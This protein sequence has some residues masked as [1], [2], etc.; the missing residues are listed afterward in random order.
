MPKIEE[1][2]P[3]AAPLAKA[4]PRRTLWGVVRSIF[5]PWINV[6]APRSPFEDDPDRD[7]KERPLPSV[8]RTEWYQSDVHAAIS[9]A[10]AGDLSMAGQ[11]WRSTRR[12]GI[13]GGLLSTRAGGLIR[14]PK[15]F[16][17]PP[18]VLAE[19]QPDPESGRP[20][21]FDRV[22]PSKELELLI[23]DGIGLGVG[24]GE[25]LRIPGRV[26]P[27]FVRLDPEFL[28]YRWSED[29][30]YYASAAG[31]LPITPGDGRWVLHMPG[32]YQQP[33]NNGLWHAIAR[34]FVA[35]EHAFM[36]RENYSGKLA[37]PA[38][39]AVSPQGAT[40]GERQ[41]FFKRVMAWGLNTVFG[42]PPGWDV[43][44]LEINGQGF[45]VFED[46]IEASNKEYA[47]A[48]AGQTVTVDGGAGFSN[49]TIHETIR[50]DLIQGDGS[51]AAETLNLQAF[52]YVMDVCFG[53]GF[54]CAVEWDTAPPAALKETAEALSAAVAAIVAAYKE[55]SALGY[56]VNVSELIHRFK[57]PASLRRQVE[58]RAVET[59]ATQRIR[60]IA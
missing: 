13:F 54:S 36:Y 29:R 7:R 44:L 26:E 14:L 41:S 42:L 1:P 27:L 52:P 23:G 60:R 6:P 50:S 47:I 48:I 21:L 51:G 37:N 59:I 40:D 22:F 2:K 5:V 19:M 18:E 3:S 15:T 30:W 32:G 55:L 56:D 20:S 33:W 24:V 45:K 31:L 35:K 39:V 46:T 11:L 53:A 16:R 58:D 57:I 9:L 25:L 10:D 17:A 34:A 12:D 8:S 28:R 38:R 4:R 49:A 43:R